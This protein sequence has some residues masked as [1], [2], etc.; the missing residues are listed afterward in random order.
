[1]IPDYHAA[2]SAVLDWLERSLRTNP[3]VSD[4]SHRGLQRGPKTGPLPISRNEA[5]NRLRTS[6][7]PTRTRP[8]SGEGI[9]LASKAE[10]C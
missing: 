7:D 10:A 6:F 2:V 4:F 3:G 8:L 5:S 1:M 9:S